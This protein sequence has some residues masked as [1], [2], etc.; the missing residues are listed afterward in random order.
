MR[1]TYMTTIYIEYTNDEIGP[2]ANVYLGVHFYS[3][4]ILFNP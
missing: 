2:P 1:A 4:V 3:L